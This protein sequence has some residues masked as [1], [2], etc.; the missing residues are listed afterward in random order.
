[1]ISKVLKKNT[2]WQKLF[3]FFAIS[4]SAQAQ[5][6]NPSYG[7]KEIWKKDF[8]EKY[9]I[10]VVS[11]VNTGDINAPVILDIP[12]SWRG[13]ILFDINGIEKSRTKYSGTDGLWTDFSYGGKAVFTRGGDE[14]GPG[15]LQLQDL[16]G[17]V[18]KDLTKEY[19]TT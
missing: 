5:T 17:N 1:M 14:A 13:K 12:N 9:E 16:D 8:T 10:G 19:N 15:D 11:F 2:T 7:I 4:I 18:I 6:P 3:L